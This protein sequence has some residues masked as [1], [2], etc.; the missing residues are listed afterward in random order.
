MKLKYIDALRGIAILGVLMVHCA[1]ENYSFLPGI[2]ANFIKD[3]ARGVQLFFIASAFT[4]FLSMEKRYANEKYPNLYFFIRRF[5]RIAP[6]YYLGICYF[7]WE[8]GFTG[9]DFLCDP[10]YITISNIVANVLFVH[11]FNPNWITSLVP[12]GWSIAVEMIFYCMVPIL[13]KYIKNTKQAYNFVIGAL[14]LSFILKIFFQ[15][16]PLISCDRLWS[17][18]LFVYLPNQLPI[19]GLGILLY[20]IIKEGYKISIAPWMILLTVG[21]LIMQFIEVFILP[22]HFLFGVAFLLLALALSKQEFKVIT[23]PIITYIGKISYSIYLVH[24]AV[25]YWMDKLKFNNY[26]EV[27]DPRTALVNYGIRFVVL[28]I[29][30]AIISSITYRLIEIPMQEI[31]KKMIKRLDR[32]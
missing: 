32:N 31:G 13:F 12:G 25:L 18:Y 28:I 29:I 10:N 21:I 6:M 30:S 3:G 16:F 26:V 7:L 5:F 22:H 11:S 9:R 4:L 27:S 2:A 19:F 17:E 20:F 24:F 1:E 14:L 23:N 15:R 8:D